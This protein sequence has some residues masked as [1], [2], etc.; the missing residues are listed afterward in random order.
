MLF[1]LILS[2][3][4]L[5]FIKGQQGVFIAKQRW[6]VRTLH[7]AT[8]AKNDLP[9]IKTKII[10]QALP[11]HLVTIQANPKPAIIILRKKMLQK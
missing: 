4:H 11:T 7:L 5:K 2:G 9:F 6:S 10:K 3:I 1:A 8:T